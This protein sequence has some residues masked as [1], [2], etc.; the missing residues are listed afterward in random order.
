MIY[1]PI[2]NFVP[3]DLL[4]EFFFFFVYYCVLFKEFA[5]AIESLSPEQQNFCRSFRGMQV[6]RNE[7]E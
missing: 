5:D 1:L 7:E 2:C 6:R 4:I 3:Y